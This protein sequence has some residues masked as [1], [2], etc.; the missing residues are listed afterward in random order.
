MKILSRSRKHP[1]AAAGVVGV[2]RVERDNARVSRKFKHGN[3]AF[4]D[5]P[6]IDRVHAEILIAASAGVVVNASP[7]SSGRYPNVGPQLLARAGITIVDHVGPG[8]WA[9]FKS[10]DTVRIDGGKIFRNEILLGAGTELDEAKIL[11]LLS[12]AQRGLTTRLESLAANSAEHLR[13][14]HDMLLEGVGVPELTTRLRNRPAV[15]VS[16]AYDYVEDLAALKRYIDDH[17][18]VLVGAGA[19]AD[20]LLDA[21]YAPHLTVGSLENLSDRAL[22]ESGEVVV[23]SPSGE[24]ESVDRLEKA[25]ADAQTFVASGSDEDLALILV[26]TNEAAVI[27]L[28][29]GHKSLV[30]FLDKG[31]IDMSSTFL[32]R[33]RVGTKLVDAKSVAEFYNHRI[34]LWPVLLLLLVALV[35]VGIAV[36]ATPVGDSWVHWTGDQIDTFVDWLRGLTK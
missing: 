11:S 18:P 27:V 29:G 15:V 36:A 22:K 14:E 1:A 19:G 30:E 34:K 25:G 26:D 12:T 7:S 3:I 16:K 24:L 17:D 35:A 5:H 4:I 13:R 31:P 2:A 23:T 10:G 8:I 21:G 32:A 28:A 20:A 9:K 6:D 33:L